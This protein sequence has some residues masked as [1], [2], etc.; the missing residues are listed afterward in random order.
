MTAIAL[1]LQRVTPSRHGRDLGEQAS[2]HR[3]HLRVRPSDGSRAGLDDDHRDDRRRA[4]NGAISVLGP[5]VSVRLVP[6]PAAIAVGE[7]VLWGVKARDAVGT[8]ME[9][10]DPAW[11]SDDPGI[12]VVGLQGGILGVRPGNG[13]DHGDRRRGDRKGASDRHR[14]ARSERRLV[15]G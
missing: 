10:W 4:R 14:T 1:D 8:L 3:G 2:R 6:T 13:R 5:I 12:A 7:E 11:R 9:Q 15:D